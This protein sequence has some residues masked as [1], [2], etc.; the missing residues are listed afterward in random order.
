MRLYLSDSFYLKSNKGFD[1]EGAMILFDG[2]TYRK[3]STVK[4]LLS[5]HGITAILD[6]PHTRDLHLWNSS[7]VLL[8]RIAT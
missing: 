5:S 3:T 8:K 4:D 6:V 7:I 1:A 2:A